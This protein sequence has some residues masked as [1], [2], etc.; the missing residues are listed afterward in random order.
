MLVSVE[1]VSDA[2]VIILIKMLS[3]F[4]TLLSSFDANRELQTILRMFNSIS[5]PQD[6]AS[7]VFS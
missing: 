3:R 1:V 5:F 7:L 2:M 4:L 6:L